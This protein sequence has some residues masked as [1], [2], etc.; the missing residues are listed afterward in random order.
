MKI[1]FT[2]PHSTKYGREE[3]VENTIG[4]TLI[5]LGEAEV[6]P[7]KDFRE[8]LRSE[9]PTAF[10]PVAATV[11]WSVSQGMINSRYYISAKCSQPQCTTLAY[12]APPSAALESITFLHSCGCA[13][14]E[15]VPAQ[16]A[17]QYRK[18]FKP[19]TTL[20]KDEARYYHD[21]RPQ[22]SK[23]VDPSTWQYPLTGPLR[24]GN[25]KEG[26][27]N[28][29]PNPGDGQPLDPAFHKYK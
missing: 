28:Y 25:E 27:L 3:H 6:V 2:N 24:E 12:D 9:N 26:L 20:G 1:R 21:A 15:K 23:P 17:E 19:A 7:Y 22:V 18:Q 5:A 4:K 14:A 16:I 10:A 8:R 11:Q 13:H 29:A